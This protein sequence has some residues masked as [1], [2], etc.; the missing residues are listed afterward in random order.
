MMVIYVPVKLNLI[1]QTVFKLG[2]GN[3]DVDGW[4]DKRTKNGQTDRIS[5]ISKGN[6][7]PCQV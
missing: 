5:P 7:S 6:L 1:G 4:T 3:K 2:S